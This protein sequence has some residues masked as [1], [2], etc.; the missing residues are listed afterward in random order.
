MTSSEAFDT[1]A[2]GEH[3]PVTNGSSAIAATSDLHSQSL[4]HSHTHDHSHHD[5]SH[6]NYAST[7]IPPPLAS[8]TRT[9]GGKGARN[10][11]NNNNNSTRRARFNPALSSSTSSTLA[12]SAP[13]F[14]P[15]TSSKSSQNLPPIRPSPVSETLLSRL[16]NELTK[17]TYDCSICFSSLSRSVAINSCSTCYTSFH[18]SCLSK[19]AIRS[20]AESS[21]RATALANRNG[22]SDTVV[23]GTWSCPGCQTRSAEIPTKYYCY[24]QRVRDPPL[25]LPA[26]PHSCGLQCAKTRPDGCSHGCS[27][28]CHPGPCP[29]CPVVVAIQ[30]HCSKQDLRVRCSGIYGMTSL[31]GGREELLS[32]KQ[33]CGKTLECGLDVCERLCHEGDCGSCEKVREKKCYCGKL[34][35]QELCGGIDREDRVQCHV[36]GDD[37]GW[38]GEWSCTS[39]CGA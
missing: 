36:P 39:V 33:V 8:N 1:S 5:H 20:V 25:R 7:S 19:W 34:E 6:V 28:L 4:P 3:L 2:G 14:F 26:T 23:A 21:E 12:A 10:N 35:K 16:T 31:A 24:C 22:T 38:T 17:G 29:S 11:N 30:C 18:L 13:A 15:P 32:C 9:T 37:N 27:L